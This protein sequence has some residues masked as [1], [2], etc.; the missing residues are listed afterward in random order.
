MTNFDQNSVKSVF[1]QQQGL[2]WLSYPSHL[3]YASPGIQFNR[4]FVGQSLCLPGSASLASILVHH[5]CR[6]ASIGGR[7]LSTCGISHSWSM[8]R[9][10]SLCRD[11][12]S[13]SVNTIW[14]ARSKVL[15]LLRLPIGYWIYVNVT[16][17]LQRSLGTYMSKSLSIYV[18][19]W[20]H[21]YVTEYICRSLSTCVRHWIYV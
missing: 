11:T 21:V 17:Y 8:T 10:T 5:P 13:N 9:S 20:V 6:L 15:V 14:N 4:T 18:G 1:V 7:S 19:H 3:H 16:E 2:V 12:M